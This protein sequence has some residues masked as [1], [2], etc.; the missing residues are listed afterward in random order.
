MINNSA[1]H[2]YLR[3]GARIALTLFAW[4]LAI[5]IM[6]QLLHDHSEF[7]AQIFSH[8]A[9][10][11]FAAAIGLSLIIYFIILSLPNTK[12][13]RWKGVLTI[14]IWSVLVVIGHGVTHLG[15][16]NAKE[17]L[18]QLQEMMG[19]GGFILLAFSY[20]I[21][22]AMPFIAGVEIG[23]LIM[24][25]FGVPG[26]IVAYAGTLIGLNLAFGI[27][28][29]LPT[30]WVHKALT[31][32]GLP[33]GHEDFDTLLERLVKGSGWM[34]K[35]G[36]LMLHN[37]YVTLAVSLNFPGNALIGGGGG[38]S[39]LSGMSQRLVSW[40]FFVLVTIIATLPVPVLVLLGLL[41]IDR[42]VEHS[43]W[44]HD[45]LDIFYRWAF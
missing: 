38:L 1:I 35:F 11:A 39:L 10:K 18:S 15:E 36:K 26:V 37:R 44:F 17:V 2:S 5:A 14:F 40:P 27:G 19:L 4:I 3:F 21:F 28:R 33:I 25:I 31:K 30:M 8:L 7:M 34:S 16:S 6:H 13:P 41:N 23:L 22:L 32:I 29:L 24:A 9:I 45:F 20:S 12:T 42:V 43:G